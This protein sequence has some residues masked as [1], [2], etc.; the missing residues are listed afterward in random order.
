MMDGLGE[1][2]ESPFGGSAG[3]VY[4]QSLS[5]SS[6]SSSCS[7]LASFWEPKRI[8]NQITLINGEKFLLQVRGTR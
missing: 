7:S 1:L 4:S 5:T 8:L 3:R 2:L 6:T